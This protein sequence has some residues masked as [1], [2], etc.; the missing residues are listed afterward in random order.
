MPGCERSPET[1]TPA[2]DEG[3][4]VGVRW[5]RTTRRRP[6]SACSASGV[7]IWSACRPCSRRSRRRHLGAEV[8]GISLVT[9]L[10]AGLSATSLDH[11]DVLARRGRVGRPDGRR[12]SPIWIDE[13]VSDRDSAIDAGEGVAGATDPDPATRAEVDALILA[14]DDEP[15]G[16]RPVRRPARVR[17]RR[18]AGR[19]RCRANRMNRAIGPSSDGGRGWR[20]SMRSAQR[21]RSWWV[22]TPATD[23]RVRRRHRGGARRCRRVPVRASPGRVPTPVL[24][25]AVLDQRRRRRHHGDGQ[26]QPAGRQRLQGL[27]GRRCPDRRARRRRDRR[28]ASTRSA[29]RPTVPARATSR[30]ASSRRRAGRPY[31][32]GACSGRCRCPPART[33]RSSTP[34]CTAWADG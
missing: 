33:V 3:V 2:L 11:D 20:G 32:D 16:L 21:G 7:P 18:A 22:A 31:L 12:C 9:N 23:R 15:S 25:F 27:R 26:P 13:A 14:A 17:D 8:L 10:A 1:S 6:R 4:Y 30:T 19:A 28:P 24:A 5:A 34:R 29:A